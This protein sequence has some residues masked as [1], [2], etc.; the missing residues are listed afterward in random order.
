MAVRGLSCAAFLMTVSGCAKGTQPGDVQDV[1]V[2]VIDAKTPSVDSARSP[3]SMRPSTGVSLAPGTRLAALA[4]QLDQEAIVQSPVVQEVQAARAELRARRFDRYPQFR[5]TASAPLTGD[6]NASIG[7]SVEQLIWDGGRTRAR[8]TDT[9]LKIADVSLRAW[10]ERN[11]SVYEGLHAYV[12]A[13]RY[14]KRIDE[15][16]TLRKDLERIA[17]LLETRLS[18]GVADRGELL[19]MN[20]ALQEVQRNI[21]SDTSSLRQAKTDFVRL[22][23]NGANGALLNDL[24]EAHSQCSRSWPQ[25]EAPADALA[26]ISM[27]RAEMSEKLVRSQRFPKVLLGGGSAYSQGGWSEP[28]ISIR[29]DASDML[30]LGRRGNIEAAEAS[31][32]A[33]EAAL[34]LQRD[35]TRAEL[36]RLESEHDGLRSDAAALHEL[37]SQ[38]A[39]TLKLFE[40]Q[41]DAGTISLVDGIVLHRENTDTVIALIDVEADI[42]LNCLQSSKLRGL[43]ALFG[44]IDEQ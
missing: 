39:A 16:G 14:Q 26:R 10:Q 31:T 34:R 24:R 43:L 33:A 11:A 29:L 38:N 8:L 17:A 7:L 2:A 21:V 36:A 19:R 41:L 22:M 1:S 32:R 44:V 4:K 35:D 25:S 30:G 15:F 27:S 20:V 28:A 23:P 9:E 42:L 13:T 37:S 18:G 5:P 3:V 40:E 6:G 12:N